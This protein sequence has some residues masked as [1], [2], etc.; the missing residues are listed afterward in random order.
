MP[1]WCRLSW[2]GLQAKPSAL[3]LL[4]LLLV[5][6]EWRPCESAQVPAGAANSATQSTTASDTQAEISTYDTSS[7][8]RI[9]VNVVPVRVV[10]R[11]QRGNVVKNLGKEDF[12]ILDNGK[13]QIIAT[14]AIDRA[15]APAASGDKTPVDTNRGTSA[16]TGLPERFVAL[17]FDDIHLS[18]QDAIFARSAATKIL[19]AMTPV[20][21]IAV[22]GDS[23]AVEQD[24]TG[25]PAVLRDTLL[26]II[27]RSTREGSVGTACPN[28]SYFQAEQMLVFH[29]RDAINLA[30]ADAWSCAFHDDP[31][32]YPAAVRLAQATA[33]Q[34]S[35]QGEVEIDAAFQRLADYIRALASKPGERKLVLVSPGFVSTE[36]SRN[37]SNLIDRALEAKVIVDTIDARGL[38]TPDM[39][40]VTQSGGM[41]AQL[42]GAATRF[43]LQEQSLAGEVLGSIAAGTG[44]EWFHNRNDLDERFRQI[45]SAPP[46]SYLLTFSPQGLKP[47]GRYHT[48]K[49]KV[50]PGAGYVVE[51]RHGYFAPAVASDPAAQAHAEIEEALFSHDDLNELPIELKTQFFMKDA[52]EAAVSVLAHFDVKAV[53]FRKAEE[54]NCDDLVVAAAIFDKNGNLVT[55]DSKTLKLRV[56]DATLERLRNSGVTIKSTFDLKPGEYLVR[57]VARDSEGAQIGGRN[58][59]VDIPY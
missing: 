30:N 5:F 43:R 33:Q 28:I 17:V 51:A 12:Q 13:P 31:K 27:P 56:R 16:P 38:Y 11:D 20:D 49:V 34:V 36:A 44:G 4:A 19:E 42:G 15:V 47:D 59:S 40:D 57:V 37:L 55:G 3:V 58:A 53:H 21:R 29:D 24:F 1:V 18:A 8:F 26:R 9:H 39:G 25:D 7:T 50:S 48:L 22:Y 32:A 35:A 52:G 23:G 45:V 6:C 14:F 46:T 41:N 10:V 54:R 2:L